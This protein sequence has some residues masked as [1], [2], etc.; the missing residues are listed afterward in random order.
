[1]AYGQGAILIFAFANRYSTL[2]GNP[3]VVKWTNH[4]A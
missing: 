4:F 1:M 3:T 2:V